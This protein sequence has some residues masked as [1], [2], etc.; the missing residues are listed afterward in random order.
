MKRFVRQARSV[1]AV[2]LRKG[3]TPLPRSTSL[4]YRENVDAIWRGDI[5]SKYT[6]VI[7]L[8]PGNRVLEIGAAEGVL[9]LLLAR[10]KEKV[11][12]LELRKER[13]ESALQLQ[14]HWQAQGRDVSRCQMLR[15]DIRQRFDLLPQVDTLVAVR[16]IYHLHED[17]QRVFE[18]VGQHVRH[19]VLCGN[20]FRARRLLEPNDDPGNKTRLFD[21]YASLEGMTQLLQHCGYTITTTVTEGDPVVVGL[22]ESVGG[23]EPPR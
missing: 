3:A 7:D 15:G 18:H 10:R 9:S 4:A 12:A 22:K 23:S 17:I 19:V 20:Q 6:R 2:L 13:H 11:I 5:P 1:M 16:T 8:V 14:A 21:R